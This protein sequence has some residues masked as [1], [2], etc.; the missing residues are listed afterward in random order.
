MSSYNMRDTKNIELSK[1]HWLSIRPRQ[2]IS[3]VMPSRKEQ[4]EDR[5]MTRAKHSFC[6]HADVTTHQ[7]RT[8]RAPIFST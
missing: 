8:A 7:H 1:I 4:R 3:A 2:S 6:K 5:V